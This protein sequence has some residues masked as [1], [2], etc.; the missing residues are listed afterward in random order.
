MTALRASLFLTT[1]PGWAF[2]TLVELRNLGFPGRPSLHHRDSSILVRDAASLVFG[3]MATPG[4]TYG[5]LAVGRKGRQGDATVELGHRL[6]APTFKRDVLEWLPRA[7]RGSLRSY[8]LETESWGE[9]QLSR[10]E[11]ADQ[12]EA[13]IHQRFP[14]W[15]RSSGN[16]LRFYYKADPGTAIL[17]V[18]LYSNLDRDGGLPGSLRWHLACGLLTVAGARPGAP[19]FDPFMGTGTILKAAREE[20]GV[21]NCLGLEIDE[22]AFSVARQDL[23]V[24]GVLLTNDSFKAFDAGSLPKGAR[25]VSNVPFGVRFPEVPTS[26]LLEMLTDA[27]IDASHLALLMARQQAKDVTRALHLR[28]QSVLVLGQ[29]AS[30]VYGRQPVSAA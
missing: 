21:T 27:R 24:P 19:V 7:D 15:R 30:I 8:S 2:A 28:S 13:A 16:G 26:E 18:Q 5:C 22:Q 11:I 4:T 3:R 17:G 10:R 12:I 9:T 6:D 20:F 29:P 14:R 25:L 23:D 1:Q